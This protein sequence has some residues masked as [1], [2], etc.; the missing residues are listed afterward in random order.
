MIHPKVFLLQVKGGAGWIMLP[1]ENTSLPNHTVFVNSLFLLY[2]QSNSGGTGLCKIYYAQKPSQ[3]QCR[4][5]WIT[6][7]AENSNCPIRIP[8][9]S[10]PWYSLWFAVG[11]LDYVTCR[12]YQLTQPDTVFVN[13]HFL[14]YV[15]SNL[16]GTL[17]SVRHTTPRSPLRFSVAQFG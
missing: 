1:A 12:K 10:T 7:P 5:V 2:V 14:L 13:S 8:P 15:Q 9:L 17:V 11:R 3:I 6:T 16:G 4:P